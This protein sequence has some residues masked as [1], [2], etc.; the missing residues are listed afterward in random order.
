MSAENIDSVRGGDWDGVVIDEAAHM[1]LQEV[2]LDVIRPGL[3]DRKG[4]CIFSSTT[5]AGSYFNELC[6]KVME[7]ARGPSWGHWHMTAAKNS[8]IDPDEF[9]ELIDEYDD[10]VKLQQEV[11]AELVVPG[12]LAFGEWKTDLHVYDWDPPVSWNW[13]GSMDWGFVNHGWFGLWALGPD[14]EKYCRWEFYFKGLEPRTVGYTI[15]K[16]LL[17]KGLTIP[18]FI[19]CDS[20]MM[21]KTQSVRTIS[22]EFSDGLRKVL[23]EMEPG[24]VKAVKGPGSRI[25]GVSLMHTALKLRGERRDDGSLPSWL[26]PRMRFHTECPNAIRTIPKLRRDENNPEDCDTKGEDHCWDGVNY[27]LST[28]APHP[29]SRDTDEGED[30]GR[31]PGSEGGRRRKRPRFMDALEEEDYEPEGYQ[32]PSN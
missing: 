27:L 25:N 21:T 19:I 11:Y 22:D 32:L 15:A 7:G 6:E 10:E 9:Q 12:G 2:W 20:Q 17:Q 16:T 24:L 30:F 18:S 28:F 29:D 23:N 4:W 1:K 31:R 26:A 5:K 13:V 3:V 8:K 14:E